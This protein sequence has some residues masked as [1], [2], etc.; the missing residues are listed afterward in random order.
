MLMIRQN[1][2]CIKNQGI[3]EFQMFTIYNLCSFYPFKKLKMKKS[4]YKT[5]HFKNL[6]WLERW[7]S[8]QEGFLLFQRTQAQFQAHIGWLLTTHNSSSKGSTALF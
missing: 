2:R 6:V 5:S 3:V 1:V 7:L 4:P 8:V